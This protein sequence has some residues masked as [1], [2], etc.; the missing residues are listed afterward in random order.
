MEKPMLKFIYA[1]FIGILLAVFIGV[2]VDAFYPAPKAP[3]CSATYKENPTNEQIAIQEECEKS[4]RE[5][6]EGPFS[7]YNRNV[8]IIVLFFAVVFLV[9][10][11][12]FEKKLEII[13]EGLL[14]GGVFSLAYSIIRGFMSTDAKA[15]FAVLTVGLVVTI[16]VGY[17]KFILPKE[18]LAKEKK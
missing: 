15:R 7:D 17:I 4:N 3:D 9:I 10:S 11:L 6:N 13:S 5:Y 16:A 8:S 12:L 1:L 18:K 14:I 2:G